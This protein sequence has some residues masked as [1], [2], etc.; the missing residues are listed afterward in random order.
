MKKVLSVLIALAMVVGAAAV[1]TVSASAAGN[2]VEAVGD[3]ILN[4]AGWLEDFNAQLAAGNSGYNEWY[5]SLP[6]WLNGTWIYAL[7][8]W[9]QII[10]YVGLFLGFL[11]LSGLTGL[12]ALAAVGAAMVPAILL[13]AV[14]ILALFGGGLIVLLLVMLLN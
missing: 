8:L 14:S 6:S 13:P 10:L 12:S 1:G 7:P 3:W 5:D 4:L 9:A 11:V 2:I